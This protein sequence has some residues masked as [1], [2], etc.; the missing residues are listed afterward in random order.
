MKYFKAK[1][2]PTFNNNTLNL[3][4]KFKFNKDLQ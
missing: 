1:K 3:Q 2:N 4:K